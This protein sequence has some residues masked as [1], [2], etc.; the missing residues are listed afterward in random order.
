[1]ALV[2]HH[3]RRAGRWAAG[4]AGERLTAAVLDDLHGFV[5]FHDLRLPGRR[6]NIDHV[7]VGPPGV[8][9]VE[10]K[11]WRGSVA[12]SPFR[13]RRRRGAGKRRDAVRQVRAQAEVLR[14]A[15]GSGVPVRSYLCVHGAEV[16]ARWWWPRPVVRGVRV[17][18]AGDL[19][20]WL[21]RRPRRLSRRKA[22]RTVAVID[23][24]FVSAR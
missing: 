19:T 10:T 6:W 23:A 3:R 9:V 12:V 22:R 5:V 24:T 4:A 1:M 13:L 16:R 15:V 20:R 11:L 8:V 18:G 17:G 7:V 14:Q 21:R 2:V